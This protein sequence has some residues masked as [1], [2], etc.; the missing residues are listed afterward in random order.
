MKSI[1]KIIKENKEFFNSSEPAKGHFERFKNKLKNFSRRG[2]FQTKKIISIS[3]LLKAASV[4]V[5]ITLSTLWAYNK[6]STD[7]ILSDKSTSHIGRQ[8]GI[9]LKDISPE[10]EEVEIY[11]SSLVNSKLN[12]LLQRFKTDDDLE[13][14][15]EILEELSEFDSLYT[16]LQAELQANPNNERIINAMI[17][18]Y[19][20]KAEIIDRVTNTLGI[21][22]V[23]V[24]TYSNGG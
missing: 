14:K 13:E 4:A 24:G 1:E 6:L 22:D 7:K 12:N 17:E 9:A 19:Q 18:N 5:L 11:Y 3:Y 2:V 10:Y 23:W 15:Q 8:K 16:N 20:L 21:R